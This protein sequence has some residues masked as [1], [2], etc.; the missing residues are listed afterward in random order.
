MPPAADNAMT[1]RS[2]FDGAPTAKIAGL[3]PLTTDNRQLT[4]APKS[5]RFIYGRL[6]AYGS[7]I[8]EEFFAKYLILHVAQMGEG[9]NRYSLFAFRSS[10]LDQRRQPFWRRAKGEWRKTNRR[11]RAV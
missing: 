7:I 9:G 4:T 5:L 1:F 8:C 3:A 6:K 10:A 11:D 2:A